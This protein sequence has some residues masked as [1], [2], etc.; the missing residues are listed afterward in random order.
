MK[1]L[2]RTDSYRFDTQTEVEAFIAEE[3]QR[4]IEEGFT[5]KSWSSVAKEKK[6][7]GEVV[8]SCFEVKVVRVLD[9][10]WEEFYD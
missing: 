9:T 5:L 8:D 4:A 1:H 10:L 2:T 3:K 6:K 7:K